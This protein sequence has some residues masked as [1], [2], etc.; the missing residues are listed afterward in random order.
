MKKLILAAAVLLSSPSFAAVLAIDLPQCDG[1]SLVGGKLSCIPSP[2]PVTPPTNPPVTP[3]V[4]PPV[5]TG[6]FPAM[7]GNLVAAGVSLDWVSDN[8]AANITYFFGRGQ[9]HI[10][11]FTTGPAS[12]DVASVGVA[13]FAGFPSIKTLVVSESP[14]DFTMNASKPVAVSSSGTAFFTVGTYKRGY[15]TLKANTVYYANI[16]N[17]DANTAPGLDSCPIGERCSYTFNLSH[18]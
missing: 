3:P 7:C 10:Y 15:P 5:S 14:C 12:S 2:T 1:F 6:G 16:K 8:K 4:T 17:E 9:A 11:K 18:N 13:E